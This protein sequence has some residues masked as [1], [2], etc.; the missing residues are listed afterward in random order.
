MTSNTVP[1]APNPDLV[2]GPGGRPTWN[3]AENRRWGW[4]NLHRINRYGLMLRAR[5]VMTLRRDID[6]RIA[7]LPAVRRFTG[8]DY[9][10]GMA[11]LRGDQLLFEAYAADFGPHC[12]HSIQSI[13]K[14]TLNLMIGRLVEDGLLDLA[15]TVADHLPEIGSGYAAATLRDVI[16]MNVAN[17]YSEDYG[18]P[19][20][21]VFDQEVAMGWR[22]PGPGQS[23]FSARAFIC[24]IASDDVINRSGAALYKSSNTDVLEWIVERLTGRSL[25]EHLIDIVEAAGIEDHCYMSTDR[26]GVPVLNGGASRTARDLARYGQI[27]AR[28]GI[29]IHDQTIGSRAFI[30]EARHNPGPTMPAPRDWLRYGRHMQTNGRWIGHGGYGGQYMLAD[31]ESGVSV[32]FFSVLEN[33]SATDPDY[34]SGVIKMCQEITELPFDGGLL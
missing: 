24:K 13:T 16:D 18:D 1:T 15:D 17:D 28:G 4:H 11:V 9:F 7:E 31:P 20:A 21:S 27:F 12:P 33:E 5:D 10:S 34:Q 2:I 14:T 6:L 26:D 23:D 3:T 30:D 8:L 19:A 29:G 22:L 32:A 25:R